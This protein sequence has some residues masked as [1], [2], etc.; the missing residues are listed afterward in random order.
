MSCGTFKIVVR[1]TVISHSLCTLVHRAQQSVVRYVVRFWRSRVCNIRCFPRRIGYACS[2]ACECRYAPTWKPH[3]SRVRGAT[4]KKLCMDVHMLR[5]TLKRVSGEAR[6]ACELDFLSFCTTQAIQI[7]EAALECS[8]K[9]VH[10][11]LR[12]L[13][14]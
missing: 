5:K 10:E 6:H 13:Q 7:E 12:R 1:K 14:P 4:P 2:F 8:C 11:I 3:W 9:H